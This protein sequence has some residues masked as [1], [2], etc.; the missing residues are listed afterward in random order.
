MVTSMTMPEEVRV[1]LLSKAIQNISD[2]LT[3]ALEHTATRNTVVIYDTEDPLTLLLTE[4]YRTVLPHATFLNFGEHTK[5]EL[6]AHINLL[7]P[8]DLVVLVQTADFRLNQFRFRIYL[9]QQKLKVIDHQ[10]LNRCTS[11]SWEIYIDALAYDQTWYRTKGSALKALLTD[12]KSLTIQ[13]MEHTLTVSGPLEVPKLN[14]GDYRELENI[15]GTFPIG[16]VFTEAK[17]LSDMNGSILIYAFA[18]SNFQITMHQPFLITIKDGLLVAWDETAPFGFIEIM[19]AISAQ[20]RPLIR[21][22]GFGL[23]RAITRERYLKDITAFERMYGMHISVG[24]KHTVYKKHGIT[25]DKTRFHVDLF[26]VVDCVKT[27]E[28]VIFEKGSYCI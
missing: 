10:N 11:E 24:E 2:T 12:A 21:E 15:G 25:A 28:R 13:S 8:R 9:F 26:P 18:G 19:R 3:Y 4:A 14:V 27:E 17:N 5:D 1:P 22:I 16:E 23:N 6:I 7:S 20:E